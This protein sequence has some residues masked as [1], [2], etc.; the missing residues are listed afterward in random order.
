MCVCVGVCVIERECVSLCLYVFKCV[1]IHP[2]QPG[3]CPQTN[4]EVKHIQTRNLH[5]NNPESCVGLF[6]FNI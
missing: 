2:K 1:Y 5:V 3:S 4:Q 6:V